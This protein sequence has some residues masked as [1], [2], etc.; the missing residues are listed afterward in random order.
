MNFLC[1][2]SRQTETRPKLYTTL[3]RS[4]NECWWHW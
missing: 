2:G 3:L 4:L 1:E